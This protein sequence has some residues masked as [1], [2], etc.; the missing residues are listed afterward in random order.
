MSAPTV[1][2]R[3]RPDQ[4]PA[5]RKVVRALKENPELSG[6]VLAHIRQCRQSSTSGETAG[7]IGPFRDADAALDTLASLLQ[8]SMRPEAVFLFG[9]RARSTERSD[10][11][12]DFLV[13]LPDDRPRALD[14]MAAGLPVAGCGIATDVV[15]CRYSDF[16]DGR[17]QAGTLCYEVHRYGH[18]IRA[19]IGG[20]CWERYREQFPRR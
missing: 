11:D 20:P 7:N 17:N 16:E 13:V 9:S 5:I 19:R 1:S 10:S 12:F 14:C 4:Q 18:L 15:P 3:I 6:P 8:T 2:F